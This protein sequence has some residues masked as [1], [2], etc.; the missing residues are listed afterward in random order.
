[1]NLLQ[2]AVLSTALLLPTGLTAQSGD[3]GPILLRL[4][5]SVRALAMGNVAVAGR[6]DDVLFYNP[7]QL[8]AARGTSVSMEQFSSTAHTGSLSTVIRFNSGRSRD[9]RDDGRIRQ[10]ARGVSGRPSGFGFGGTRAR[11]LGS[12]VIGAAQVIKSIRIGGAAKFV[13]ERIGPTRSARG[14]FDVGLGRD[15][16]GYA[17][18][19]AV[20]NIGESFE[21]TTPPGSEFIRRGSRMPLR[22]TFGAMRGWNT[23]TFDFTATAAVS[24]LRDGFV[25]PAGGAEMFYSW[26]SGY[27]VV[28]RAGGRRPETGRRSADRRRR[29]D[30]RPALARLRSRDPEWIALRPPH[31]SSHSLV[32]SSSLLR[33]CAAF[34]F[35]RPSS[36]PPVTQAL[37]LTKD[38][39]PVVL[40]HQMITAPNPGEKGAF[41]VKTMYYGS[42]TD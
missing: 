18:G 21:P 24:V 29:V 10:S 27:T 35:C 26:L 38:D 22:S 19:L 30:R 6:D 9:R 23:T 15:F 20:Q 16:F 42:G 7:A 31:R 8:V 37:T 2:R 13:D 39:S 25:V 40:S 14:V 32:S 41:A 11:I 17:F 4:P 3:L 36:P 33:S 28:V 12:L 34:S 1:M 5:A